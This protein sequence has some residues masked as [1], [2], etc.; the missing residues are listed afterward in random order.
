M[1][2]FLLA[3]AC[4]AGAAALHAQERIL[5]FGAEIAIGV[6]GALQVTETIEVHAEG[7]RIRRGILRDFP[8]DYRDRFGNAVRVGFDVLGVARDGAPEPW[9]IEPLANGVRIRIGAADRLLPRGPHRYEIRYRT[10]RQ[11][12]FFAEHD[13]L[14][15]NVTGSGWNFA[16]D[17]A[18]TRV[19]LP[20]PVAASELKAEAY[21]GPAGARGR[22]YRAAIADGVFEFATTKPL[23]VREGLTIVALFPK[24]L[25]AAPTWFDRVSYWVF[26]NRGGA[27][28]VAGAVLALGFLWWRWLRVG[29]DPL[30]GPRFPRYDAPPG[31]SAAAVRYVDRMRFD[32]RCFAAA[33]LDL[34]SR[35]YLTVRQ[36]ADGFSLE[37][38][39]RGVPWLAGDKPMIDKLLGSADAAQ[40]SKTYDPTVFAAQK[41]LQESLAQ[42][43]GPASFRL[44]RGAL[45][46]GGLI[47]AAGLVAA[48]MMNAAVSLVV[49]LAIV[50]AIA[51]VAFARWL[52]AYTGAGRKLRDHIDGLRQYLSVAERDDLAR[53]QAPAQT[54]AE[55]ARMLPY[56]L[57]LDV[58]KTWADRFAALLGAAAVAAAVSH[59]YQGGDGFDGGSTLGG[60]TDG[61][62][63]LGSTVAAAATPPGSSSGSSDGGSGDGGSSGGGGG[64]G[65]DGW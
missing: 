57:A 33:V 17:R 8:T 22:D 50:L 53:M 34:G 18:H 28:G 25:V 60:F 29:R 31:L 59:Y 61:L 15:W 42:H 1:K 62:D 54:P 51:L 9:R 20:R 12:G 38:T 41:A 4:F 23:G 36:G 32:S 6:D 64:G 24:G 13:E 39:G 35:G 2:R 7:Q 48:N 55:F 16:I 47:G 65:G 46:I 58:E 52:P 14:Y 63:A 40:V 49:A 27:V 45:V 37:R 11:L 19:T 3:L 26:D 43:Y 30:P 44:N 56:A 10:T 21:T 5:D